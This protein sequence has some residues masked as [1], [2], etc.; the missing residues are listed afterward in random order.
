MNS[1]AHCAPGG[2]CGPLYWRCPKSLIAI[3]TGRRGGVAPAPSARLLRQCSA[4]LYATEFRKGPFDTSASSTISAKLRVPLGTSLHSTGGD[5]LSASRLYRE[6]ICSGAKRGDAHTL[7]IRS[8]LCWCRN[9]HTRGIALCRGGSPPA[10]ARFYK[11]TGHGPLS[12][13]LTAG[14][15]EGS[16]AGAGEFGWVLRTSRSRGDCGGLTGPKLVKTY[17][18]TGVTDEP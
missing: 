2:G 11:V 4:M 14:P 8:S 13:H 3:R 16:S 1:D 9:S 15:Q 6:G 17:Q 7:H 5:T 12:Y 10:T 18:Q